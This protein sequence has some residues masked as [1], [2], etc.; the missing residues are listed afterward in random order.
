MQERRDNLEKGL[1]VQDEDGIS[2][3][4]EG[5]FEIISSNLT[6]EDLRQD[7]VLRWKIDVV[8]GQKARMDEAAQRSYSVEAVKLG[9]DVQHGAPLQSKMA[10]GQSTGTAYVALRAGGVFT[11]AP[12][13]ARTGINPVSRDHGGQVLW[14]SKRRVPSDVRVGK[15]HAALH[16][17][18]SYGGLYRGRET[19]PENYRHLER[20]ICVASS[21]GIPLLLEEFFLDSSLPLPLSLSLSLSLSKQLPSVVAI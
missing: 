10:E 19:H 2:T 9:W 4:A 14:D 20:V 16:F 21:R 5:A 18:N 12:L 3:D 15:G 17:D 8:C 11:Q 6:S 13:P 1:E 7:V